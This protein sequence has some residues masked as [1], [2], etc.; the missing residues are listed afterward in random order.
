MSEEPEPRYLI[1]GESA[2]VVEFGQ[3]IDPAIHDQVLALDAALA[4]ANLEGV[5][6]TVPT[7]RSIMIHF[8][9]RRLTTEALIEQVKRLESAPAIQRPKPQRWRIPV[10]YDPPLAE[11]LTEVAT[12]LDLAPERVIALH[13]RA[14]YR[15]YMYGF[16]PGFTFLG[17]LPGE[18]GISRRTAPRPPAPAGSLMIAG[19]QALITSFAMPTGWYVIG[20]TPVRVFDLRRERPFLAN[21][22]D[23]IMFE[24]I[25]AA[26]F[27]A[28]SR[29]AEAGDLVARTEG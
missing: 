11:D 17:G 14:L 24:R 6:E 29:A 9:P 27:E 12:K 7:Y 15:V 2:L 16:S 8:D 23:E 10:C 1:A 20:R 22:G 19:G 25:D 13:V 4:A 26:S 28:L 21:I 18:L 5:L 3:S